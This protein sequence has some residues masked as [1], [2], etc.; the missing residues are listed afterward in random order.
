[1]TERALSGTLSQPK[2]AALTAR[3]LRLLD[4]LE[5]ASAQPRLYL[6]QA[7]LMAHPMVRSHDP[8]R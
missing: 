5:V 4:V 2:T 6:F 7:E 1:M 8:R 3:V